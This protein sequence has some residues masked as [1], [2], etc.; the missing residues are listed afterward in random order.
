MNWKQWLAR[1]LGYGAV[2]HPRSAIS[3]APVFAATL[4]EIN[5]IEKSSR[6]YSANTYPAS[7]E[8]IHGEHGLYM[9]HRVVADNSSITLKTRCENCNSLLIIRLGYMVG[10][11]GKSYTYPMQPA[12]SKRVVR[13]RRKAN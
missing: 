9:G 1:K 11:C 5:E 3:D 2:E 10:C 12:E 13:A 6:F 7:V 4:K 8:H